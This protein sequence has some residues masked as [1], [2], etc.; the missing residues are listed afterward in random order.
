MD[1]S[2]FFVP[3]TIVNHGSL[4]KWKT[5][6]LQNNVLTKHIILDYGQSITL[7][8]QLNFYFSLDSN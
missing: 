3:Q 6:N 2:L 1:E 8:N 4:C 5:H 7:K